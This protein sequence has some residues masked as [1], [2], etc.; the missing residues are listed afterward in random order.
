[1]NGCAQAY[2]SSHM[3]L[4]YLSVTTL[5]G[6]FTLGFDPLRD[7]GV[8]STHRTKTSGNVVHFRAPNSR[9]RDCS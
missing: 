3:S 8:E 4:K 2:L 1:M 7:V 5:A 9:I 6:L